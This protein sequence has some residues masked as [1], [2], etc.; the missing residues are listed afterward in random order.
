M[1]EISNKCDSIQDYEC[2]LCHDLYYNPCVLLCGHAFCLTCLQRWLDED[3]LKTSRRCPLCRR[4]LHAAAH[5]ELLV[6]QPLAKLL[7]GRFPADYARRR[8][9]E[10][11]HEKPSQRHSTRSEL[12]LLVIDS[13]L[14]PRQ[15]LS[16]N[17]FEPR[18]RALV[19]AALESGRC[20]G[21]VGRAAHTGHYGF[22]VEVIIEDCT[23][24][25]GDAF[26]VRAV[27]SRVFRILETCER[28]GAYMVATLVWVPADADE[29]RSQD[30][31]AAREL[32]PLLFRWKVMAAVHVQRR[33]NDARVLLD[34][35]GPMPPVE[36][37][38]DHAYWVAALINSLQVLDLAV[39]IRHEVLAAQTVEERLR[40]VR[41]GLEHSLS[42][43][44]AKP[45]PQRRSCLQSC[46]DS[47]QLISPHMTL[48]IVVI[49]A[50]G[51]SALPGW[52][53]T[54]WIFT[55]SASATSRD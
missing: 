8:G 39:D 37:P 24:L 28:P 50:C 9:D 19:R 22:G 53:P 42:H 1:Q 6:C 41:L 48:I 25:A 52:D 55:R 10:A 7:E 47:M 45:K 18:C 11:S 23:E 20:F 31:E 17:V 15:H 16:M 54:V 43:F 44:G 49:I 26:H 36:R 3:T 38:G 13:P 34:E 33:R 30:V 5:T 2:S 14:L 32:E 12:P 21:V 4:L 27:A 35:L 46:L 51:I 40:V 29:P